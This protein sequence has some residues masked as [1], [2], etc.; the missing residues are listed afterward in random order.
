MIF[1]QRGDPAELVL[2]GGIKEEREKS[3]HAAILIV[4]DL[5]NRRAHYGWRAMF[6]IGGTPA[7]LVSLL[8]HGVHEPQRWQKTAPAHHGHW[9][10]TPLAAIFAPQY[11]RRTIVNTLLLFV[12]IVGLWG[13]SVYLPTAVTQLATAAGHSAASRSEERRV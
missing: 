5:R 7:L 13:G 2:G 3:A 10:T 9:F 6:L 4:D 1:A 11:R 8:R 12:S